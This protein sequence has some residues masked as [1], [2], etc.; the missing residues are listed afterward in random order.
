MGTLA[1]AASATLTITATVDTG[2]GGTN[3]TNT[4]EVTAVD[5]FDLDSTPNNNVPSEDDQESADITV[6]P[7]AGVS[8]DPATKVDSLLDDADGNGE[9][10]PGDTL[11]YTVTIWN[12]GTTD[13]TGV[14]FTDTPDPNTTLVVGS[15]TTTKGNVIIGNNPGDM[16]VEVN[17][18]TLLAGGPASETVTI[19]IHVIINDPLPPGVTNIYNQGVFISNETPPTP[20]DD[21]ATNPDDDPTGTPLYFGGGVRGVPVF[22]NM[23]IG[24]AAALGAGVLAYLLRRRVLGQKLTEN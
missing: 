2:I 14:V 20:T 19:S 5:Q 24:I 17:V 12:E 22:P 9:Y 3:I 1:N 23:Y 18:G 21:P 4:A 16:W 15:V 6:T 11:L 8:L 13:A 7:F 10:S